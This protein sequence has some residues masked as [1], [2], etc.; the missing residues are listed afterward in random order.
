MFWALPWLLNMMTFPDGLTV[1]P[2]MLAGVYCH[3]DP[4][5]DE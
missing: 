2:E 1:N 5:S 3:V 4:L